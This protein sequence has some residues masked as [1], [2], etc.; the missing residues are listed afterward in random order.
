MHLPDMQLTGFGTCEDQGGKCEKEDKDNCGL[1]YSKPIQASVSAFFPLI[2]FLLKADPG[3]CQCIFFT[4]NFK[5]LLL[6]FLACQLNMEDSSDI[7]RR[8]V[9]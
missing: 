3:K 7:W 8:H 4:F 6:A 2:Y 5:F 1:T 9:T